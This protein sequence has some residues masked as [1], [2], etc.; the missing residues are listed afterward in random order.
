MPESL[1]IPL[2][3]EWFC[4]CDHDVVHAAPVGQAL[5][6]QQKPPS[7]RRKTYDTVCGRHRAIAYAVSAVSSDAGESL[8]WSLLAW[9]PPNRFDGHRRCRGCWDETGRPRPN[10]TFRNLARRPLDAR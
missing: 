6:R 7:R 10:P 8:G 2:S 3:D 4:V 9:P 5:R 1:F